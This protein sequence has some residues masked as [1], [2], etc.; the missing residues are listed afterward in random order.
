M[1]ES[2]IMTQAD[3]PAVVTLDAKETGMRRTGYYE[4]KIARCIGEP[5]LNT[6]LIAEQD[7]V[8]V[9]FLFG[10]LFFG[11]FGIPAT[12]AVIDT[13]G[14]HPDFR[15]TGIA[16]AL[17]EQ[18]R[19]NM[20]GLRVEAIDTLVEW[21]RFDLLAFFKAVG[22]R[23]SRDVDLA[24]DIERFPFAARDDEAE[25]RDA[26]EA[27]LQDVVTMD[28]EALG[29]GRPDYF[30]AKWRAVQVQ[31]ANNRFL[32]AELG[33]EPAGFMVAGLYQGEFGIR[34]SRGVIDSLGVRQ[35]FQH[36]G[37][38]SAL[39]QHLLGWLQERGVTQMETLCHW[40]EW[41]LLRFFEYVGFRP[42]ARVNLEWRFD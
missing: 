10:R 31:P 25:V 20:A 38:A 22:F 14:V 12:R 3:L 41:E 21:D 1:D 16:H 9:G 36:R 15:K 29:E 6:S 17:M 4:E 19:K 40:N 34:F 33:G 2:R 35:R 39:L 7:G 27:D 37:V 28:Q 5:R 13:L 18:Y 32:I 26:T 24:W 8:P 42:S 11:E 30:A 23:P